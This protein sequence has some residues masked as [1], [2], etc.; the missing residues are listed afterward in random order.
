MPTTVDRLLRVFLCHAKEDK[1]TVRDLH[2]QLTAEGWL[3][4]WLDEIKLL[5]GQ[6]WDI[7]IE[8]AVEQADVVIVCLSN[9]SVD[10]EGYVQ[11]ELRFV[12]NIADE[13]P[14]GTIFV[15]PLRLDDCQVPRRIRAWQYVDYFPKNSQAS[16]YQRLIES[17][18]TDDFSAPKLQN[19]IEYAKTKQNVELILEGDISDFTPNRR[20]EI[21][22]V[23]AVLLKIDESNIRILQVSQGS[24]VVVLEMPSM[25]AEFLYELATKQDS[26]LVEKGIKSIS[27]EDRETIKVG[28]KS[29]AISKKELGQSDI[30]KNNESAVLASGLDVFGKTAQHSNEDEAKRGKDLREKIVNLLAN[31]ETSDEAI[32]LLA[33]IDAKKLA[34]YI[35]QYKRASNDLNTGIITREAY[36]TELNKITVVVID[37]LDEWTKG[38]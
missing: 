15:I 1:P 36:I 12:L 16:A 13:K 3:D 20:K 9:K 7:E 6:E 38:I 33:E 27:L 32:Q 34:L 28:D 24:I 22:G 21:I 25:A 14:E 19:Q 18:S 35:S 31:P 26:R 8:K 30:T 10:K 5:P 17:L 29:I 4:V 23:L 2:R 37:F 11:K